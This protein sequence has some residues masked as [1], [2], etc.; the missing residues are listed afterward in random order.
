VATSRQ[1]PPAFDLVACVAE[2]EKH[3]VAGSVAAVVSMVLLGL[4]AIGCASNV[5]QVGSPPLSAQSTMAGVALTCPTSSVVNTYLNDH[6]TG[7]PTVIAPPRGGQICNYGELGEG[8]QA[9]VIIEPGTEA[10]LKASE[11]EADSDGGPTGAPIPNLGN[12][13]FLLQGKGTVFV[14]KGTT[15][16]SVSSFSSTDA[17]VESLARQIVGS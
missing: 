9:N 13:A 10:D 15:L 5:R 6:I 8:G 7:P 1:R 2:E 3:R 12:D 11:A 14:L 4:L 17:Q 16:I